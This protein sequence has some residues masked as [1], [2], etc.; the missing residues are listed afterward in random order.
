MPTTTPTPWFCAAAISTH[1]QTIHK[2][3]SQ[4]CRRWLVRQIPKADRRR[5]KW[6][7]SRMVRCR[8]RK[9]SVKFASTTIHSPRRMSFRDGAVSKSSRSRARTSGTAHL[10]STSTTRAWILAIRLRRVARRI[11]N[12]RTTWISVVQSFLKKRHSHFTLD[13]I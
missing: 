10:V 12:A 8:R 13:A 6:M 5:S 7:V 1:C 11:N 3:S 2:H 9:R 4:R